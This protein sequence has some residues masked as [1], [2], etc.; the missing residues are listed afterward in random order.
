MLTAARTIRLRSILRP[1]HAM[2]GFVQ[3]LVIQV[4][5]LG[6]NVMTSVMTARMLGVEGRGYFTAITLWGPL[7]GALGALSIPTAVPVF[8]RTARDA[9]GELLGSAF[10]LTGLFSAVVS[11]VCITAL[12]LALDGYPDPVVTAALIFSTAATTTN[13]VTLVMRGV[14][15]GDRHY[16]RFNASSWVP[17]AA[18]LVALGTV[19]AVGLRSA[20]AAAYCLLASGGVNLAVTLYLAAP[21]LCRLSVPSRRWLGILTGYNLRGAFAEIASQI[22]Q[23]A[24][25]LILLAVA[26]PAELGLYA[27]AWSLSRVLGGVQAAVS[28]VVLAALPNRPHEEV[29]LLGEQALRLCVLAT[30]GA[31]AMLCLTAGPLFELLF[32]PEFA[33]A[34]PLFRVLLVEA[35][36]ACLAQLL[37]QVFN[38]IGRPQYGSLAHAMGL[39]A[40]A[41][42]VAL[43]VPDP[44]A[45]HVAWGMLAGSAVRLGVLIRLWR[46]A[47]GGSCPRLVPLRSDLAVFSRILK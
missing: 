4:L 39:C 22:L 10:A 7:V 34:V 16:G 47:F 8:W 45:W 1:D 25:R 24:D 17:H 31:T 33:G 28:A 44:G 46:C 6:I 3:T 35:A 11:V 9:Q 42:A 23:H 12:P 2:A 43:A 18:Y 5:S 38:V 30:V 41:A 37:I 26:R 15:L 20:E 32:G 13:A 19:F 27:V 29:R 14:L 40:M 36:L 21:A